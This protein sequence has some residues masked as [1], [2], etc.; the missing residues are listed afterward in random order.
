MEI[1]ANQKSLLLLCR[2]EVPY[3]KLNKII[4]IE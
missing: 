4:H 1:K 3:L 2:A